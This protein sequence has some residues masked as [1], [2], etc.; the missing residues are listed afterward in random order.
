MS[1]AVL[2]TEAQLQLRDDGPGLRRGRQITISAAGRDRGGQCW[3]P[4][5]SKK[6][7]SATSSQELRRDRNYG[8]DEYRRGICTPA[9]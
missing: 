8:S 1:S 2:L 6:G 5:G 7:V 3:W 9:S 4:A